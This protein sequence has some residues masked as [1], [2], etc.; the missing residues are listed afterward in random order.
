MD[1][2]KKTYVLVVTVVVSGLF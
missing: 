2:W 1:G